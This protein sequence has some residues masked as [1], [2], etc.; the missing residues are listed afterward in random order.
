M[1][2][3]AVGIVWNGIWA[4]DNLTSVVGEGEKRELGIVRVEAR[5]DNPLD[6]EQPEQLTK[7]LLV[8]TGKRLPP[9]LLRW[10]ESAQPSVIGHLSYQRSSELIN[11]V[12]VKVSQNVKKA[13][14]QLGTFHVHR[15][16]YI[17]SIKPVT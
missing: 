12:C 10:Q 3:I 5:N 8:A 16:L 15:S 17:P 14:A 2:E 4:A 1:C 6:N 7:Q 13:Q 9:T 11:A